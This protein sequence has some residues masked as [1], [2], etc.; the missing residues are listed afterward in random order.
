M[1]S[2]R[3][4]AIQGVGSALGERVVPNSEF[5]PLGVDDRWVVER[6][7]I[8]ERHFAA[9]G[10]ATSDL[11]TLAGRRALESAGL[12][13]EQVDLLI[14]GTLTPDR[15]LPSASVLVQANLGV[16]CPAFDLN[17]ACAGFTYGV[18]VAS[19]MIESGAAETAL[20]IGA[21]T[22][23][24]IMNLR[25][26]TTCVLF[27]D[28]SGAAVLVPSQEPGVLGSLLGADGEA[29]DL[30]TIPDGGSA[31]PVTH[32]A[33][34]AA[35]NKVQMPNGPEVFRRAVHAMSETCEHLMDKLGVRAEDV[36]LLIPHQANSRIMLS[37]AHRLG[38][39]EDRAVMDIESVGNTSSASIPIALDRAWRAG[40]IR[41]GGLL[42]QVAF[43]AGL[44]WGA[45]LI[46][47]TAPTP[48]TVDGAPAGT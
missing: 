45:N 41:P 10:T 22:V 12:A 30:L 48:Q 40:R 47:W 36:D 26:R 37:V 39:G 1:K 13:P 18:A 38:I 33:I 17:A 5:A 29:A 24:R 23:S 2:R 31:S 32:Q 3:W 7:G 27:G 44:S 16:S 8:R 19:G 25:D 21:E 15:P 35:T 34:E 20:V 43:G 6:T 42:L 4:A 28:G 9:E 14:V 46:R 11:A